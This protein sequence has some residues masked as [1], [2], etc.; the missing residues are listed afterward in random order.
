MIASLVSRRAET[1]SLI[2]CLVKKPGW[3]RGTV[4]QGKR[5]HQ[6]GKNKVLTTQL[7]SVSL[8]PLYSSQIILV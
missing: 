8:F 2:S 6:D 5:R 1:R 4:S 3:E 7:A